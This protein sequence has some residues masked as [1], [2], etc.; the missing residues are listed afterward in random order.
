MA[1]SLS[2]KSITPIDE[3]KLPFVEVKAS[4]SDIIP[5]PP[6]PPVPTEDYYLLDSEGYS[7]I[8]S[9]DFRLKVRA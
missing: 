3:S 7:L 5:V 1:L 6:T 8:D 9:E 4:T 2:V